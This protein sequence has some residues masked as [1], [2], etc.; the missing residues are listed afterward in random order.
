MVALARSRV[1][2]VSPRAGAAENPDLEK[3]AARIGY[4]PAGSVSL[5][6]GDRTTLGSTDVSAYLAYG[7][8]PGATVEVDGKAAGLP[9]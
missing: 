5:A 4:I 3:A 7:S 1:H 2:R 9:Y 8:L 6:I